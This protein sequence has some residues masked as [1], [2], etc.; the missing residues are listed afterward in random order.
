MNHIYG[1]NKYTYARYCTETDI[2]LNYQWIRIRIWWWTFRIRIRQKGPDPTGSGFGSATLVPLHVQDT[3][4]TYKVQYTYEVRYTKRYIT[5][6]L[7][8][9]YI[10]TS[11]VLYTY[12]RDE[13]YLCTPSRYNYIYQV[14]LHLY[15]TKHLY[16]KVTSTPTRYGHLQ[17]R[18]TFTPTR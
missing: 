12:G 5:I 17:L 8:L 14:Q 3:P 13:I 7:D 9:G 4:T 1:V 18:G 15:S 10:Y 11:E 16:L 2:F 6:H